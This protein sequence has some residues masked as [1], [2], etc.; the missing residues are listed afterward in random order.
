MK[1]KI[2]NKIYHK[3][4]TKEEIV[5]LSTLPLGELTNFADTVRKDFLGNAFDICT[6]INGKS[7]KC[8][9]NCKFCAQSAHYPTKAKEYPLLDEKTIVDDASQK[10]EQGVVRYS[11]VTSG[12]KL[13]SDELDHLAHIYPKIGAN[14][15]YICASHGLLSLEDL[16]LLRDAGVQRYHNN[17]ETSERFFPHVCT[18]HTYEDKLSTLKN[19]KKAG[20]EIC[21]GGIFGLGETLEDRIDM[22]FTLKELDVHSIPINILAAIPG[23]PFENIPFLSYDEVAR[24]VALYRLIHP[25]AFLRLAGGRGLLK[26]H[27]KKLLQSGA[28]ALI[29]GD[30]LTTDGYTVESDLQMISSLD[31]KVKQPILSNTIDL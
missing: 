16:K 19:A 18:T 6:I 15:N 31:Y 12:K 22:A 30:M 14:G 8:S 29:T 28:N 3:E 9:E 27:G 25:D 17:L 26:D 20:M 10:L 5:E 11:I 13:T 2:K 23:T 4:I 24:S 7:G 1:Q 21:S